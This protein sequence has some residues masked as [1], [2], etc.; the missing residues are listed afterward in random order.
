MSI[1]GGSKAAVRNFVRSW[2]QDTKGSGIR[3]NILSP[4]AVDTDSLRSALAMAQG[5]DHVDATIKA[6]GEGNPTGRLAHPREIGK[7]AVFL[8]SDASSFITGIE[9]FVDGGMAQV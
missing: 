9:L 5:A 8:S 7:A 3:M 4:G 6:R 2:I 1:Y